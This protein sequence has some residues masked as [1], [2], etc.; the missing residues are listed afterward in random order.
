MEATSNYDSKLSAAHS[1]WG[2]NKCTLRECVKQF[3]DHSEHWCPEC[4]IYMTKITS[5]HKATQSGVAS[6]LKMKYD[7]E[8]TTLWKSPLTTSNASILTDVQEVI[9][10]RGGA[11]G[12][13]Y[14]N[15]GRTAT[16]WSTYLGVEITAEDVCWMMML[17]KVSRQIHSP[18]R[19]NLVD[20]V[21]YAA[22]VEM[23]QQRQPA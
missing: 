19:D 9:A 8:T 5:A 21:G 12:H 7:K 3:P 6:S 10:E 20:I 18:T 4:V 23:I 16:M 11:Y 15:H 13:P 2:T 14:D 17:L 22:N 1:Q